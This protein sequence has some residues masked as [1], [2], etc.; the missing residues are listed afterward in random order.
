[1]RKNF[2]TLCVVTL[3]MA[4]TGLVFAS[5]METQELRWSELQAAVQGKQVEIVLS[6]DRQLEG[7]VL[8]VTPDI[9]RLKTG[10]NVTELPRATITTLALTKIKG[11]WRAGGAAIGFAIPAGALGERGQGALGLLAF[12]GGVIGHFAGREADRKTVLIRVLP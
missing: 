5:R 7:K 10:S 2:R 11:R 4:F 12:G 9:L 8:E 1:M 3:T 6:D